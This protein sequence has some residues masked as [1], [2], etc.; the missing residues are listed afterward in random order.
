MLDIT[1]I[2]LTKNESLNISRCINS[3]RGWVKRIIVVDSYSTDN[4]VEIAS[5]LGAEIFYNNFKNYGNQF[6]FSLENIDHTTK[7]IFRL[8]ADEE[9]SYASKNE[10]IDLCESNNDSSIS[11]I[12]FKLEII[13]LGKKLKYG[14][15][16]PFKKL[17]IFKKDFAYMEDREMDEQ[18]IITSGKIIEMK[19]VS[20]HYDY[21][22]L[23][24]WINKHNN[25][26][27]RAAFDLINFKNKKQVINKLDS[28]AK[29]RRFFKKYIFYRIP[30]I[31]S[32]PLLFI[33]KYFFLLGFLDGKAGFYFIFFQTIWYRAL[34]NA[35]LYE[36]NLLN[37][38]I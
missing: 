15:N 20:Y 7:W 3:I 34:I 38:N 6:K 37:K 12:V 10:I 28:S 11:G 5:S 2:I 33:Y 13:F 31:F 36:I 27:T 8:D 14:G 17:C 30:S 22:D 21:K 25:Y 18:I 32:I 16:Y 24:F 26:S 9:V 1:V 35:K 23:S 19:T 29:F 4:T